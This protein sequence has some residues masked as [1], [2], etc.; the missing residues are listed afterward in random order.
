[1]EPGSPNW[2]NYLSRGG[3]NRS[4]GYL[5]SQEKQQP[6]LWD[7]AG[8]GCSSSC[9]KRGIQVGLGFENFESF[10]VLD[11][12]QTMKCF[13]EELHKSESLG[14]CQKAFLL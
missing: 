3:Q 4:N 14:Y 13:T 8:V 5:C 7:N 11:Y 1:M 9:L 10:V 2:I 12:F 6:H